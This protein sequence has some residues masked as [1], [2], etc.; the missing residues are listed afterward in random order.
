MVEV[1]RE[2]LEYFDPRV[3]VGLPAKGLPF[4]W[5][6]A[7]MAKVCPN[8]GRRQLIIFPTINS[9]MMSYRE[10]G[11]PELPSGAFRRAG[12]HC[13]ELMYEEEVL[14]PWTFP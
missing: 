13:V 6:Y 5:P 10:P 1:D 14:D 2:T 11:D 7:D 9:E 3:V 8:Q 4:T 12:L